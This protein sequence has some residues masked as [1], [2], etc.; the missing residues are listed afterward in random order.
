MIYICIGNRPLSAFYIRKTKVDILLIVPKEETS[1]LS[2]FKIGHT[3]KHD[4]LKL[5]AITAKKL[6]IQIIFKDTGALSI[7]PSRKVVGLTNPPTHKT[8]FAYAE[9]STSNQPFDDYHRNRPPSR[10]RPQKRDSGNFE[11]V[12]TRL[13]CSA[14]GLPGHLELTPPVPRKSIPTV[15]KAAGIFQKQSKKLKILA[16]VQDNC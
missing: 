5:S 8:E 2:F 9:T 11:T 1:V 10:R 12:R 4:G 3:I 14:P 16:Y 13:L 7:Y 6:S 15:C